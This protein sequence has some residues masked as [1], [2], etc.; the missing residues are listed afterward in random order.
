MF[1]SVKPRLAIAFAF[2]SIVA[3]VV[4]LSWLRPRHLASLS[5]E[6]AER[7][8]GQLAGCLAGSDRAD[9]AELRARTI[10]ASLGADGHDYPARCSRHL[11]DVNVSVRAH[12]SAAFELDAD[13]ACPLSHE[14][15]TTLDGLAI[16]AKRLE[17]ALEQRRGDGMALFFERA[18]AAGFTIRPTSHTTPPVPATL[19]DDKAMHPLF[20]G[21]AE[22]L[23]D[24]P[25]GDTLHL[26]FRSDR[27]GY[28]L[29]NGLLHDEP[30]CA[31]LPKAIP[32]L[33]AGSLLAGKQ[34]HHMVARRADGDIDDLYT[35]TDG[36][37][38]PLGGQA[39]GG[40][41]WSREH[42]S[43]LTVRAEQPRYQLH[44]TSA[45]GTDARTIDDPGPV[46]LLPTMVWDTLVWSTVTDGKTIMHAATVRDP[47]LWLGD[48]SVA[49]VEPA[50]VLGSIDA[51]RLGV[52]LC[53]SAER[54]AIVMREPAG[55]GRGAIAI[56]GKDRW[57]F[58]EIT[59][60]NDWFGT[61]C[62][63]GNVAL[64]WLTVVSEETGAN[65]ALIGHYEVH[66]LKCST[67][68]CE[69]ERG[70]ATLSRRADS[71]RFHVADLGE[72]IVLIWQ[73][74]RGDVRMRVGAI[75]QLGSPGPD[76]ALYDPEPKRGFIWD[77]GYGWLFVRNGRAIMLDIKTL[78]DDQGAGFYGFRFEG[79][80]VAPLR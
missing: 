58:H 37:A 78:A 69:H 13:G 79:T 77:T 4:W 73:S 74:E 53:R 6:T 59:V 70:V 63:E 29:C 65:N 22:I 19:L 71:G 57:Y 75:D 76:V 62:Q 44:G 49:H 26:L 47:S 16:D 45:D 66:R 41:S 80:T 7:A 48:P 21:R 35:L 42:A 64:T 72:N 27:D 50:V 34:P 15:C 43:V 24:P 40:F 38:T 55:A 28:T 18:R 25:G 32:S 1:E 9:D 61:T 20:R 2:A 67:D 5:H 12:M 54:L 14:Q 46:P 11:A 31:P 3:L 17:E 68:T 10:A 23:T 52:Q 56:Q 60:D 33:R 30:F 8:L 36:H 51:T 39:L